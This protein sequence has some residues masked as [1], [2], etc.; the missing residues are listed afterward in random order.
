MFSAPLK[1]VDKLDVMSSL[2]ETLLQRAYVRCGPL[3]MPDSGACE[4][5]EQSEDFA[6]ASMLILQ[7]R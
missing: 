7:V 2:R 1:T 5:L 4:G 6:L 3:L